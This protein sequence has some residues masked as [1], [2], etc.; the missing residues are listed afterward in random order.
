MTKR[1]QNTGEPLQ[2]SVLCVVLGRGIDG[3]INYE[4]PAHDGVAVDKA[5]VTAVRTVVA[6]VSHREEFVGGHHNFV[7]SHVFANFRNPFG[8][9]MGTEKMIAGRRKLIIQDVVPGHRIWVVHNVGFDQFLSVDVDILIDQLQTIA[10]Q[11]NNAFNE[12][13]VIVVRIFENDNVAA[14]ERAV[15]QKLFV[16]RVTAAAAYKYLNDVV[17]GTHA[18]LY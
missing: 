16:P 13:L 7:A 17:H 8:P 15:R 5:P 6:I 1:V 3:P 9:G 12:M 10:G 11:S 4:R 18:A 14:L 2:K